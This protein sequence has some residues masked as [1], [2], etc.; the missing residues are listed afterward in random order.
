MLTKLINVIVPAILVAVRIIEDMSSD[1]EW[2]S[3]EKKAGALLIVET[4][5]G[6]LN[7]TLTE[8]NLELVGKLVDIVVEIF[9][10]FGGWKK[11]A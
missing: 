6:Y 1:G 5:A 4:V 2:T 8:D 11:N 9:N 7:Y 3:A 10:R